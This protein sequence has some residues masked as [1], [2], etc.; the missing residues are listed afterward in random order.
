MSTHFVENENQ[1]RIKVVGVGGGGCN[2]VNRMIQEKMKGVQFVAINTDAQALLNSEA[3][4]R[5]RIGDKVTRGLGAGGE[6]E[7]GDKAAEES[8]DEI[9]E[10][11]KG[12][13]MV[14]IA[15]GM[16]GGTG[17]G[18]APVVAEIAKEVN[19]LTVGVVTKPFTFEGTHRR[20]VAE[21]GVATLRDKV[22]TL[23]V[24]PNDRILLICDKRTSLDAAFRTAD[25]VLR[26]AI[27]GISELITTSGDINLD[28]ADVRSIMS[29]S[30][31][32]L[33][34]IGRA[35]GEDRAVEA[36]RA[37]ISSPLLDC[38]IEGA[39]GI[40]L[41]ICGGPDLTLHEVNEA[42]ALISQ[43]ADP[44]AN[45][46]F[47]IVTDPRMEEEIKITVIATGFP[48]PELEVLEE[49]ET[50]RQLTLETLDSGGNVESTD[51][52]DIPSFLR[53]LREQT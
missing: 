42:A 2:A 52:F 47:G 48:A 7:T 16:G 10:V 33:M 35:S 32:A 40:L 9:Y 8:R 51:K 43:A 30:G 50:I 19:A 15:A 22:D 12:S 20:I 13:D 44:D 4:I 1:A 31:Q 24:I 41:N 46:I 49:A 36:A 53:N 45:I 6:S 29:N 23:V 18:A 27:Q 3:P 5:L 26:Q 28:F 17:T 39:K 34:A 11:L 25:D 38:S 37:A 14:F 21:D